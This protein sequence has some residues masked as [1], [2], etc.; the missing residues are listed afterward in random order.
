M[1]DL[2]QPNAFIVGRDD[3]HYLQHGYKRHKC[4][5]QYVSPILMVEALIAILALEDINRPPSKP[6]EPTFPSERRFGRLQLDDNNLY[7]ETFTLAFDHQGTT[8]QYFGE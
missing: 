7:A 5:G 1:Q 8:R 4:L 6:G 3:K 2:D